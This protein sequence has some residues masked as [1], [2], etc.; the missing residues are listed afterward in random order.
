MKAY[1]DV[2]CRL[3][4]RT[5]KDGEEI[6]ELNSFGVYVPI[7]KMCDRKLYQKYSEIIIEKIKD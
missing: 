7:C 3:C 5:V 2:T 1:G 6:T 4:N